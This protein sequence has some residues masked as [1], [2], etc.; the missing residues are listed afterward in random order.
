MQMS[1]S[2][3]FLDADDDRHWILVRPVNGLCNR[4]M[5]IIAASLLAED[6]NR[7]VAVDWQCTK[8]CNCAWERL[9]K[10]RQDL[11]F[12]TPR[13]LELE[14]NLLAGVRLLDWFHAQVNDRYIPSEAIKA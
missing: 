13:L 14:E 2:E 11:H 9:F 10:P 5:A 4:L 8:D 6:L 12:I 7:R 1:V 3:P